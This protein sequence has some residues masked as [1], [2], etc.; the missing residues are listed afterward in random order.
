MYVWSDEAA[1]ADWFS[2]NHLRPEVQGDRNTKLFV[3][4]L[5]KTLFIKNTT[6]DTKM[7]SIEKKL[8]FSSRFS[9]IF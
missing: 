4:L 2:A 6:K 8:L 7:Y 9:V 1:T 3:Q 5:G